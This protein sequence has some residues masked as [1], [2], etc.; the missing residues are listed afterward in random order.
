VVING[1]IFALAMT[2]A[3]GVVW[4]TLDY[5][6]WK[7]DR[8]AGWVVF[9]KGIHVRDWTRLPMT[10]AE[11][12]RIRMTD[13]SVRGFRAWRVMDS[14]LPAWHDWPHDDRDRRANGSPTGVRHGLG[15]SLDAR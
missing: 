7:R 9:A 13:K 15:V 6:R 3:F 8:A 5:R 12:E 1:L 4:L 2:V 11:R 10:D 14:D